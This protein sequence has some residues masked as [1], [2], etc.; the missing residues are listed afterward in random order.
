MKKTIDV[1]EIQQIYSKVTLVNIIQL[2]ANR[3]AIQI[4]AYTKQNKKKKKINKKKAQIK[5]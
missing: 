2:G 4:N 5:N 3:K 1:T